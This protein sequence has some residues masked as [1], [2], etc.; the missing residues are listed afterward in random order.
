MP[1]MKKARKKKDLG[2]LPEEWQN[3]MIKTPANPVW[4]K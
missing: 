1:N 3:G 2:I 4:L